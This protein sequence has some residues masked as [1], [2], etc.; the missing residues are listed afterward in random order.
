EV[1]VAADLGRGVLEV[2]GGD[3]LLRTAV[4]RVVAASGGGLFAA[5][6]EDLA[7]QRGGEYFDR[8]FQHSDR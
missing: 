6:R 3:E 2:A 1:Q 5:L 8:L 4:M 7:V